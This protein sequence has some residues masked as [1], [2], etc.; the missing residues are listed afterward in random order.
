MDGG[1]APNLVDLLHP[2]G[3]E[4]GVEDAEDSFRDREEW[5]AGV[6]LERVVF[7]ALPGSVLGQAKA[8]VEVGEEV[9]GEVASD[10]D[11][12]SSPVLRVLGPELGI[13]LG[14]GACGVE[15]GLSKGEAPELVLAESCGQQ[16]PIEEDALDPE[17]LELSPS[18][19]LV[20]NPGEPAVV[21][22]FK[23]GRAEL[24]HR[25]SA[26]GCGGC[27]VRRDTLASE[28]GNGAHLCRAEE[29]FDLPGVEWARRSS[30]LA[31]LPRD[32]LG[33]FHSGGSCERVVEEPLGLDE[34]VGPT[35]EAPA[36]FIGSGDGHGLGASDDLA[37]PSVELFGVEVA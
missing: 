19:R 17:E 14:V 25:P 37:E 8:T 12:G 6:E 18:E 31:I 2:G 33:S 23:V 24:L 27:G 36:V 7:P 20:G 15:V 22:G 5:L 29:S 1:A 11:M 26:T 28:L 9:V 16:H 21:A 32:I 10:G 30:G 3:G 35:D 4:V 13:G 34:P